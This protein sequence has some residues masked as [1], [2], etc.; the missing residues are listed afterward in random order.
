MAHSKIMQKIEYLSEQREK[1]VAREGSHHA[2]A[3]DHGG[4]TR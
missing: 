4:S 1:L 3:D 2:G